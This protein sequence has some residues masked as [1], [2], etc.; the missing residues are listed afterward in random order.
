MLSG[1]FVGARPSRLCGQRA[2]RLLLPFDGLKAR[3]L[4]RLENLCSVCNSHSAIYNP[5]PPGGIAQLVER[6]LCKLDVRGSNPLASKAHGAWSKIRQQGRTPGWAGKPIP[7]MPP[8]AGVNGEWKWIRPSFLRQSPITVPR[9]V[10]SMPT[11]C[12]V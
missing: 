5:Q 12:R 9:F 4:H 10:A 3:R 1:I 2:S 8:G 11:I 6:Q 7:S